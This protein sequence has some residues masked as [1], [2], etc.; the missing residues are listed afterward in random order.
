METY[1][2]I[3]KLKNL[4][5]ESICFKTPENPTYIE[6]ILTNKSL[7]FKNTYVIETKL[8]NFHK[9]IAAVIKMHFLKMKPQDI[10]Y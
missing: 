9:M 3:H 1:C 5:K 7:S 8:P 2:Q 10:S 6:L 4:M